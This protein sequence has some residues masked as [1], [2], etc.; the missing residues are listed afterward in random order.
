M[1][2]MN[3]V[4]MEAIK[5][6]TAATTKEVEDFYYNGDIGTEET[7]LALH[8]STDLYPDLQV[9]DVTTIAELCSGED[10]NLFYPIPPKGKTAVSEHSSD[11]GN[12]AER[13]GYV[14]EVADHDREYDWI[15]D[16]KIRIVAIERWEN[17]KDFFE[18][19]VPPCL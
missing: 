7:C 8:K 16:V 14:Y 12:P 3:K 9:G 10:W 5:S 19:H 13:L 17:V 1:K 6:Y 2:K 11:S 18:I 15:G 4:V